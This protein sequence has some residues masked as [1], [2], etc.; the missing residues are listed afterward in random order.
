MSEGNPSNTR[1]SEDPGS[2]VKKCSKNV[3]DVWLKFLVTF[4]L[5]FCVVGSISREVL[6]ES[7]VLISILSDILMRSIQCSGF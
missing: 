4:P 3:C 2:P 7:S 5:L 6:D 1:V